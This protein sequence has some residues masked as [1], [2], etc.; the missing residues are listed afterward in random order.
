MHPDPSDD[1]TLTRR[2]AAACAERE[3]LLRLSR[4]RIRNPQDAEDCVQEAMLRCVEFANLDEDRIGAFLTTVTL[5]LCADYQRRESRRDRLRH[6]L[7]A[8]PTDDPGPDEAV[9]D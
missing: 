6:R 7:S 4:A 1:D 2:W 9:C 8:W 3:R 5:R